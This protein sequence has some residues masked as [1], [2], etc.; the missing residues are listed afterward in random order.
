MMKNFC[1]ILLLIGNQFI[2]FPQVDSTNKLIK[3]HSEFK[4][5]EGFYLNFD[6]VKNNNPIP[7]S[8][9]IS[10]TDYDDPDFFDKVL[11]K[12]K[13]YYFD[14]IG[15][16][17][18]LAMANIWGYSRNGALFIK[19]EDGFFRITLIGSI[20]HFV[21][22][23]TT[24]SNA[25]ASPYYYNPYD[26]FMNG[27]SANSNTEMKQYILDFATGRVL[28]YSVQGMEVLLMGDPGLHDEYMLLSKKKK[29]QMMFV[30]IR[31][32]N[33]RNPLYFP[34]NFN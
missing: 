4:F 25:Y 5:I 18:E 7:K 10:T 24:Y 8:R 27:T 1:M 13:I 22:T 17:N 15:N 34:K 12:D 23:H 30:Y 33:E 21:A 16:K 19:I 11:S 6:Q 3:Y 14:N 32:F 2:V 29:K 28:D 9:I 20:C 31:K 26:P